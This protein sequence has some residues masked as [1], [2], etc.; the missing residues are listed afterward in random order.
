MPRLAS[1]DLAYVRSS[2][3]KGS[4]GGVARNTAEAILLCECLRVCAF[5]W[6]Q[7]KKPTPN[8]KQNKNTKTRKNQKQ[9]N[10]PR[11]STNQFPD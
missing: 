10:K 8:K 11:Y 5:A 2:P 1:D 6:L 7:K 4:L 3:S 9:T